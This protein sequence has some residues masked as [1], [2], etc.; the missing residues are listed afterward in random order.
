MHTLSVLKTRSGRSQV[1]KSNKTNSLIQKTAIVTLRNILLISGHKSIPTSLSFQFS[2]PNSSSIPV[3]WVSFHN[4]QMILDTVVSYFLLW[5]CDRGCHFTLP[6]FV[7]LITLN[8]G[9]PSCSCMNLLNFIKQ[10]RET[11]S[12]DRNTRGYAWDYCFMVNFFFNF[13]YGRHSIIL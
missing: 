7:H 9:Q 6:N 13:L 4:F 3:L 8:L 10:G 5:I 1:S 11:V 12:P 2:G